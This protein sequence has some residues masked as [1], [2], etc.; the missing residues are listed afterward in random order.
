MLQNTN[1]GKAFPLESLGSDIARNE[2]NYQSLLSGLIQWDRTNEDYVNIRISKDSSPWFEDFQIPSKKA[3]MNLNTLDSTNTDM[4]DGGLFSVSSILD[5]SLYGGMHYFPS[6]SFSASDDVDISTNEITVTDETNDFEFNA[7]D[8][9]VF[10]RSELSVMPVGVDF[11]KKYVIKSATSVPNRKLQFYESDGITDV[12]ITNIGSGIITMKKVINKPTIL[13]S[14]SGDLAT[15]RI[16]VKNSGNC[17]WELYYSS[18]I[19]E[20]NENHKYK[21]GD[22][23][24]HNSILYKVI[25]DFDVK[26]NDINTYPTN[27]TIDTAHFSQLIKPWSSLTEYFVGELISYENNLYIVKHSTSSNSRLSPNNDISYSTYASQWLQN[28]TYKSGS[29]VYYDGNPYLCKKDIVN[30][31]GTPDIDFDYWEIS[32][33]LPVPISGIFN[34]SIVLRWQVEHDTEKFLLKNVSFEQSSTDT[35]IQIKTT[36]STKTIPSIYQRS[37]GFFNTVNYSFYPYDKSNMWSLDKVIESTDDTISIASRQAYSA[38]MVFQHV[39]SETS[40]TINFI[41]YDGPDLDQGLCIYLVNECYISDA[42]HQAIA[43]PEDGFTFDFYFRIWP[44]NKYTDAV[45]RDHIINKSQIYIYNAPTLEDVNNNTCNEPIAKFSMARLTNFY[46]FGE[47]VAIPDKP[48]CYRATFMYSENEGRF[49]TLDYYQLP[50]HLFIG[51]VG[52]IDPQN[53][54]NLGLNND[55]ISDINP[56]AQYIGYETA[57][58]PLF[59][60]PFSKTDLK[61]F[62]FSNPEDYENFKNRIS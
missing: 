48:V 15:F 36:I 6:A 33:V 54:G 38:T 23:V 35:N 45:T 26:N 12:D 49:I 42:Y 43:L 8:I 50:D 60:D 51:P 39:N 44:N 14:D 40:K 58:F 13:T 18:I 3:V 37:V 22:I 7:G 28:Y 53:P 19:R 31:T 27:P 52:F 61:P 21:Y 24:I 59:Q 56:N 1:I 11:K 30:S 46:M 34:R 29:L 5:L 4:V 57:G 55:G 62:K 9:V 17:S 10:E 20:F 2:F 47:N 16:D 25:M 41:N 32:Y